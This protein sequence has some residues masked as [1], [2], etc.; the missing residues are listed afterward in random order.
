LKTIGDQVSAYMKGEGVTAAEMGRRVGVDRQKIENLVANHTKMP[1]YLDALA[2]E[3][4]TT[5][6]VLLAGRYRHGRQGDPGAPDPRAA[7]VVADMLSKASRAD[8]DLWALTILRDVKRSP[9][10]TPEDV[11]RFETALRAVR[12]PNGPAN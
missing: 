10:C 2:A 6:D 5:A 3:M 7:L 1:R 4:R 12:G 8:Y 11:A 9:E